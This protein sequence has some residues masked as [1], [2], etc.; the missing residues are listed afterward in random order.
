MLPTNRFYLFTILGFP[1]FADISWLLIVVLLVWRLSADIFPAQAP[2]F[3]E[4]AYFAMGV[5]GALGLF[6]SILL[7]EVGHML[8]ARR[9][10]IPT[11]A[12]TLHLFGGLAEMYASPRKPSEEATVALAGPAVTVILAVAFFGASLALTTSGV[13]PAV[14]A[15]V[16]Y[17]WFINLLL[18]IFNLMPAFPLD[19]GRVLHSILWA[20]SG[21]KIWA[22]RV[23]ATVGL[24]FACLLIGFGALSLAGMAYGGGIWWI[25]IGFF[26][27]TAANAA[28]K[29]IPV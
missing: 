29:G 10:R 18:L 2:G 1:V 27:F 26:L 20:I 8:E 25:L 14:L 13:A 23:A 12:I 9:R 3:S 5:L 7:H 24:V 15:V 11:G 16:D 17:L 6:G 22:M 19:G 28:R 4:G 21:K